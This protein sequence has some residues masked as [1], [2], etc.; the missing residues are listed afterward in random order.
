MADSIGGQVRLRK[1]A[2]LCVLASMGGLVVSVVA[3]F[4]GALTRDNTIGWAA[5]WIMCFACVPQLAAVILII[6][7]VVKE[8][9]V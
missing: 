9:D 8:K 1:A 6:V 5:V 2:I 7:D 4:V 3:A